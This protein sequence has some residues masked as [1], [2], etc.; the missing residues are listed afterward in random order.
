MRWIWWTSTDEISIVHFYRYIR[1]I[2]LLTIS[3]T[4]YW[5]QIYLTKTFSI[6][7]LCVV[8]YHW[9]VNRYLFDNTHRHTYPLFLKK[10]VSEK[11]GQWLDKCVKS[12]VIFFENE[13]KNTQYVYI[14]IRSLSLTQLKPINGVKTFSYKNIKLLKKYSPF[15]TQNLFGWLRLIRKWCI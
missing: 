11:G 9:N 4:T 6:E 5:H 10:K 1:R 8:L 7:L 13:I 15:S 2:D 3:T 14:K 12:N